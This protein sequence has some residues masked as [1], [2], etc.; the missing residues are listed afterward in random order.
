MMKLD[1]INPLNYPKWDELLLSNPDCSFFHSSG[2]TRVLLE[3]YHYNPFYFTSIDKGRLLVAIPF[4]EI[5]SF[6]TG[7]R[8]IS[9]PFSDY[10]EPLVAKD[11]HFGDVMNSLITH[12]KRAG[13]K[14]LEIRGGSSFFQGLS[15]SSY[16]Y[17]H[18]LDLSQNEKQ[19]F[20]NFKSNT[21]RNI[22]KAVR[23]GVDVNTSN[24][25]E[26]IKEFSRLN[27][28][29]R[30]MHGLPPQPYHFFKKIYDHIISQNHGK[31]VL[32][33][34]KGKAV[35]GSIYFHFGKKAMYKY[36]ASDNT[37]LHLRANNLVMWEAI[38]W[39]CRN[40]YD[41]FCF[42]KTEPENKG[43]REYKLKWGTEEK[44]IK[45]YKYD[46]KKDTFVNGKS[47]VSG[48]HNMIFNKMPIPLLK[49][50]SLM[51]YKHIG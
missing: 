16:Y 34:H 47:H 38:K 29:T 5:K 6:L 12:G 18:N 13:W 14:F 28:M 11:V 27:C 49:L 33:Y 45:Y 39:Y 35:A 22:K 8:G 3:S 19:I 46:L 4:M 20:S 9:L 51:L 32:A 48:V 10:C 21:K 31:V 44:I 26:S 50:I 1:I 41:N 43:L 7:V 25:L 24:S 17:G 37:Y 30:R 15:H 36:G 2:W 40:G 42:G 23:E